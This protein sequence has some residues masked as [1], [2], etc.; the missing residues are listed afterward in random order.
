MADCR[1]S[2]PAADWQSDRRVDA[3]DCDYEVTT[4]PRRDLIFAA[5][6]LPSTNT[7]DRPL[8]VIQGDM[9]IAAPMTGLKVLLQT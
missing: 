6:K 7:C 3:A 2:P 5:P 4:R 9:K 1:R 8:P